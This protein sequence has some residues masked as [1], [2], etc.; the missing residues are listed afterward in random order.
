MQAK[1]DKYEAIL[2]C[3]LK[4]CFD[5]EDPV[6]AIRNMRNFNEGYDAF[7][8]EDEEMKVLRDRILGEFELEMDELA[9][10]GS[11][12]LKTGKY[13]LGTL[14]IML[15]KKNR[16]RLTEY[17][18]DQVRYWLD[19]LVE[20]WAHA[21][22]LA[23]KILPVLFELNLVDM[24]V[25]K[26]WRDSESKWTRRAAFVTFVWLRKAEKAED[27]LEF[28]TPCIKET[29]RNA[30]AGLSWLITDLWHKSSE[31]VEEYLLEHKKEINPYILRAVSDKMPYAKAKIFRPKISRNRNRQ[32]S[33]QRGRRP[34]KQTYRP[35][36]KD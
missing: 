16:P 19:E 15:L 28:I 13:E 21:D 35:R 2:K 9:D 4:F 26:D 33:Q 10:L 7:G 18:R 20:N 17:I 11:V 23:I 5:R 6:R 30:Q 22:F 3:A 29:D 34:R 24:E 31:P 27:I 1:N 32:P 12:F 25:W 8:I 36:K 14:A